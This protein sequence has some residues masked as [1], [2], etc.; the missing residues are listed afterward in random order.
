MNPNPTNPDPSSKEALAASLVIDGPGLIDG[1]LFGLPF[2]AAQSDLVLLPVPW[3]VTTSYRPGTAEGPRLILEASTQI[4]LWDRDVP[5]AW[6]R[7]I[8]MLPIDAA[9]QAR[10]TALRA[11]AEGQ[12]EAQERGE[13]PDPAALA[14]VNAGC[15]ALHELIEACAAELLD[16]HPHVG[17]VGGD[18][19]TPLGFLRALARR[20]EGFGVLQID[21]HADL[22]P[23]YEG[24]ATSHA[25]IMHN[26][27]ALPQIARL[28]QVGVRDLCAQEVEVIRGSKGRIAC[29]FDADL[30]AGRFEGAT[31]AEQ[32]RRILEPLPQEV[33]VSFDI[34]GLDPT[35]CPG[36]G[37]PVPG[38]L[39]FA[40]VDYLLRALARSGR[41]IIGFDLNE[42]AS[43]GSEWDAIVGARALWLLSIATFLSAPAT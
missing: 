12:I 5:E 24:F 35:L 28:V 36:T 26:A 41:R 34:D 8:H 17:L 21:A 43:G 19:S 40:Q 15:E 20:H 2:S 29:H 32:V 7:G 31:W 16:A 33:Y 22:R 27:L 14:E 18:H 4:D 37:T 9:I 10:S 11:V 25:S 38:G 6:R 13:A 1:G 42:V 3:D 23:G 39:S 30:Q